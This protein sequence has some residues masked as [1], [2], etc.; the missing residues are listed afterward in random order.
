M[1]AGRKCPNARIKRRVGRGGGS[2][3]CTGRLEAVMLVAVAVPF[4]RWTRGGWQRFEDSVPARV[5]K[6]GVRVAP[7][8]LRAAKRDVACPKCGWS[9]ERATA[10]LKRKRRIA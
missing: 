3:G 8:T 5:T 10:A 6:H 4:K 2:P 9:M 1:S 7:E